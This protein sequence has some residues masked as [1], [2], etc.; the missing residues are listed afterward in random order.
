MNND[1]LT[2]GHEIDLETDPLEVQTLELLEER[3][4]VVKKNVLAGKV[5][6]SKT[7]HTRTVNV[8]IEL[9]EE[10]LTIQVIAQDDDGVLVGDYDDQ[11]LIQHFDE[12]TESVVTLNDKPLALGE[13]VEIIL[14]R[15]TATVTKKTH[16]VEEVALRT[17]TDTTTHELTTE[18]RHEE[19]QVNAES[20][21]DGHSTTV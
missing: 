15:E 17:Y 6:V 16:A 3:A 9:K 7:V 13:S 21:T 20:Y 5:V 1:I 10:I 18:L 2:T 4:D 14:S 19:L 8:P 11:E 12:T